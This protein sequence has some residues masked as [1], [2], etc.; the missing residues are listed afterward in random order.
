MSINLDDLNERAA[1]QAQALSAVPRD[2]LLLPYQR[3]W[4]ADTSGVKIIEKS[5]RTGLTWGEA[6]DAA[7]TAAQQNGSGHIYSGADLDM[8]AEFIA[9]VGMWAR[10]F[11]QAAGDIGEEVL[12]DGNG[13]PITTYRVRFASGNI[14]RALSS[15]PTAIRGR[16]YNVTLDEA[17]FHKN[18]QAMLTA[19]LPLRMWGS[20][21]RIISTHNGVSSYFNTLINETRAERRP[22]SFHSLPLARALEDGL[23]KRICLVSGQTWTPEAEEEWEAAIRAEATTAEDAEE[24]YDCIPKKSGGSYLPFDLCERALQGDVPILTYAPPAGFALRPEDSRYRETQEWIDHQ[25][26]PLL[27]AL[28]AT[29]HVLGED[30]ARSMD[31]TVL[32]PLSLLENL[33]RR[34]PFAVEIADCPFAQQRQILFALLDGLPRFAAAA[35]DAGGNGQQ[36]AEDAADRYGHERIEQVHFTQPYYRE[37][38]PVCK[39]HLEDDLYELPQSLDW[40]DDL[41]S[42]SVVG[43]V[44]TIPGRD[45]R[46][47]KSAGRRRHG[48]A[49]IALLLADVAANMPVQLYEYTD[50]P[51]HQTN[52]IRTSW[53]PDRQTEMRDMGKAKVL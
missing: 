38:W 1:S 45:T 47:D 42:V 18:F 46:S 21:I 4:V 11:D 15:N 23:Y 12:E 31:L 32:L 10:A 36:L 29:R 14:V 22:Y 35:L 16:Q 27:D 34:A 33:R 40:M 7:L 39:A 51:R 3:R 44:P 30:F 37:K 24:E 26:R 52:D 9:A 28:P 50:V 6:A 5:R 2:G 53:R 17:A 8:A 48:D 19:A 41:R 25:L 49:A 20:K 43:G 13:D